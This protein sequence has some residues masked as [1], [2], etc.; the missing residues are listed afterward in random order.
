MKGATGKTVHLDV[1]TSTLV[2]QTLEE[3]YKQDL[4]KQ[5]N[6]LIFY[7]VLLTTSPTSIGGWQ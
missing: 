1:E 3:F 6:N 5:Q 4:V 2:I 7:K